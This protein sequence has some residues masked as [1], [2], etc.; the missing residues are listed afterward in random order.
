MHTRM[1]SG[2]N[3]AAAGCTTRWKVLS[4]ATCPEP[5]APNMAVDSSL[6]M[7]MDG[8]AHDKAFK[9]R[10]VVLWYKIALCQPGDVS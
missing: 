5:T 1:I 2:W 10:P 4:A 7:V 6:G 8:G 3:L 9:L